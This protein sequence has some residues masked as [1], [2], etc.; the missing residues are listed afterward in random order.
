VSG[1]ASAEWPAKAPRP[2]NS[3]LN[4]ELFAETFFYRAPPWQESLLTVVDRILTAG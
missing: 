3:R 4:S 2:L 1:I